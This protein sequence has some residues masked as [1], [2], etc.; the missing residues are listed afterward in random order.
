MHA[1]WLLLDEMLL[2]LY[3]HPHLYVDLGLISFALPRAELHRY[4]ERLESTGLAA[5]Y[6]ARH[7]GRGI[8]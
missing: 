6:R 1:R 8:G 7:R 4:L 5:G 3:S 2:M